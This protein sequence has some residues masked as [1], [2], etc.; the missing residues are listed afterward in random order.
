MQ[1][2][3]D[4]LAKAK[5]NGIN[6]YIVGHIPPN[7]KSGKPAYSKHCYRDYLDLLGDYGDIIYGHFHGHTN[8][9]NLSL[10]VKADQQ[11][12]GKKKKKHPSKYQLITL[13]KGSIPKIKPSYELVAV[14]SNSPSIVPVHNPSLRVYD[15]SPAQGG[16]ILGYTQFYADLHKANRDS[17]LEFTVEYTPK[18]TYGMKDLSIASWKEFIPRLL[19]P[20]TKLY[21]LYSKFFTVS[22][23]TT[24]EEDKQDDE[25]DQDDTDVEEELEADS[26]W[27]SGA[28]HI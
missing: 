6:I 15:F 14:L 24:K 19:D 7:K 23:I 26:S 4:H 17:K 10:L 16:A 25:D 27:V 11:K 13:P 2:L 8:V 1:W 22:A 18:D 21:D 12:H 5:K 3:E 20:S 9:D 28:L